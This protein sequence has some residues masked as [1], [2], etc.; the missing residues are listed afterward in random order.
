MASL[1][2]QQQA[3][4]LAYAV[5][6]RNLDET[7]Y[8]SFGKQLESG[9]RTTVS[10]VNALFSGTEGA[11][12][13]AGKTDTQILNQVYSN[14]YKTTAD[15]SYIQSLLSSGSSVNSLVTKM[16]TDV[17]YYNGFD[18]ATLS[19]QQKFDTQ[20]DTALYT[21]ASSAAKSGA[22]DVQAFFY[23]LGSTQ[24]ASSINFWGTQIANGSKTTTQVAQSF[25]NSKAPT[26]L[27]SDS[28]FV[29]L[30]YHNAYLRDPSSVETSYYTNKLTAGTATRA[31]VLLEVINTLRG[32]VIAGDTTAQTQFIKATHVYNA[33]ELPALAFQEQVAA[34]FLGIPDR[35]V[36]ASGLDTWS[37][38][39]AY[40]VN[41]TTLTNKL[42]SSSESQSK[43][44]N[45][46]GNAFIQHVFT[47]VHG[48]AATAAQLATYAALGSDKAVVTLAIINDLRSST[49]TDSKTVSQ[50]HG[51]EADIGNSLLYKTAA[52]LTTSAANGNATGTVNSDS[53]HVLSNA[54]TAVLKNVILNANT[55]TVSNL[56]FA[57]Q[58]ANLTINGTSAATVNLSDNGVNKGVN[59]TVNNAN[60]VLNASSGADNV[61]ITS[62]ADLAAS[63]PGSP[64]KDFNLGA[65][66]D[67][68]K[69]AGN[70]AVNGAN[71]VSNGV[72]GDGGAGTDV[73]SANFITKTVSVGSVFGTTTI[74]S[75]ASQFTNFEKIDLAGYIGKA[76]V[77]ANST[78]TSHTFD[79]GVFNGSALTETSSVTGFLQQAAPSNSGSQGFVLS[80]LADAVKVI[81][82]VGGTAAQ[83][84]VTGNAT[85][86]S[87]VGFTFTQDAT[88]KFD[89]AFT[90]NGNTDVNAG[91]INLHS[92]SLFTALN[93]V[94]I[95]SGG[96][97]NFNNALTLAGGNQVN[98]VKVTGDHHLDLTVGN[99]LS[100]SGNI[101][102]DASGNTAGVNI[103]AQVVGSGQ[104][105]LAQLI[106]LFPGGPIFT[107][108]FLAGTTVN[109]TGSA[110]ADTFTLRDNTSVTGNG[111]N[112]KFIIASSP[113][114][115]PVSIKDYSY[116]TN[117][118]QDQKSGLQI[119]N[120]T[121]GTQVGDYGTHS[122]SAIISLLNGLG[123]S[124][125]G[126]FFSSL[127]GLSNNQ[128]NSKVGI[129][130]VD[131]SHFLLID[132]N[133]DHLLGSNDTVI[134][135]TGGTHAELVNNL[136]Y[137]L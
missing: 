85:A 123:G 128:L 34:L 101:T 21:A 76:T 52:T 17:L 43:G 124:L 40:G 100:K 9:S 107:S 86:A 58:L 39:L 132:E 3:T 95:A 1:Y 11:G 87:S 42:L 126:A 48:T 49:A 36:D 7:S 30:L 32:T 35:G 122:G 8:E 83:L 37:K 47:A 120:T 51:Y 97:G 56:K 66:N 69:W 136:H 102:I 105:G 68:L 84:E 72:N 44:A 24:V 26:S 25:V 108:L 61:T 93:S 10:F 23:A 134:S 82:A 94:N 55:A 96:T 137:G 46:T 67:T 117:V 60:V 106:N 133:N 129:S 50:Q 64:S 31:D 62:T 121:T 135:L 27:Y 74:S 104:G 65:G 4:A 20:I 73:L 54:E 119:S 130:T 111:G 33:G 110:A 70:A 29:S 103:D 112:D 18:S 75:S 81:N 89:I 88:N 113:Q 45:L 12:K 118:I 16:V 92:A 80:G 115:T 91:S 127:F 116:T 63:V 14:I 114:A 2:Y 19:A 6:G 13:F 5:L 15:A 78:A 57:D 99:A 38:E 90:A 53:S 79:Y 131:N 28:Q 98:T 71:T 109:I 22:A 77:S 41:S 125:T 59:V